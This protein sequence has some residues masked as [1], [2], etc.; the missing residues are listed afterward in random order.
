MQSKNSKSTYICAKPPIVDDISEVDL[1][2]F[3]K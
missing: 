1:Y 2:N 3:L